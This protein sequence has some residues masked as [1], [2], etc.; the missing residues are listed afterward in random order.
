MLQANGCEYCYDTGFLG[1]TAVYDMMVIDDKLKSLIANEKLSPAEL[2]E[3]GDKRGK[4][5]LQKEGLK[6]VVSGITS[7]EELNRVLG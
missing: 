4:S 2:S 1:R 5:N 6:K 3:E 7:L